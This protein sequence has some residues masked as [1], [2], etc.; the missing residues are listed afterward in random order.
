[1]GDLVDLPICR[2]YVQQSKLQKENHPWEQLDEVI[3][4]IRRLMLKSTLE[5]I[6]EEKLDRKDPT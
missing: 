3:E 5:A 1:M 2:K 6:N 4:G